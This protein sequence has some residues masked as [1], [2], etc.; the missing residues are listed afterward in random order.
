MLT[1]VFARAGAARK[2]TDK[3]R[4]DRLSWIR[5]TQATTLVHA[6]P[7]CDRLICYGHLRLLPAPVIFIDMVGA[8]GYS[9]R[10]IAELVRSVNRVPWEQ[11]VR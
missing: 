6:T 3:R 4:F 9:R 8:Q 11:R 10:S 7:T 1:A 2:S 5:E